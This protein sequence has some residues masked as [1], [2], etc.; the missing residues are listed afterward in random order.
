MH[1]EWC[2]TYTECSH[3]DISFQ[4][5]NTAMKVNNLFWVK[6]YDKLDY[7][8]YQLRDDGC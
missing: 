7:N 5:P 3:S 2:S 8:G 4:A 1:K 6:E